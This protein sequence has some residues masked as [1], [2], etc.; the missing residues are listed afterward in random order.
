MDYLLC[1]CPMKID[2]EQSDSKIVFLQENWPSLACEELFNSFPKQELKCAHCL[3]DAA[4]YSIAINQGK[5]TMEEKK[6][7][8]NLYQN[9]TELYHNY[10]VT[11]SDET[12]K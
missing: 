4:N 10:Q 11:L 7:I 12:K 3:L 9:I 5:Y 1:P 2:L 8:S 6:R